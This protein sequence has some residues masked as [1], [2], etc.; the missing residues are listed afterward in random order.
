MYVLPTEQLVVV[1][2]AGLTWQQN[3]DFAPPEGPV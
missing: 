2:T 3:R 1:M